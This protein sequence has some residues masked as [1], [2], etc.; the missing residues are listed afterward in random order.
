MQQN[1]N[2]KKHDGVKYY[3]KK[4]KPFEALDS[5]ISGNVC[6][7]LYCERKATHYFETFKK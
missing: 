5:V 1:N 4:H 3:C 7:E 6:E 2:V